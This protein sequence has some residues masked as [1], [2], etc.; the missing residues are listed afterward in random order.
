MVHKSALTGSETK[1]KVEYSQDSYRTIWGPLT[2]Q[3]NT[4]QLISW[5]PPIL[6]TT[7]NVNK[8]NEISA[9][10][11][12]KLTGAL[13]VGKKLFAQLL[14]QVGLTWSGSP[15]DINVLPKVGWGT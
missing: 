10:I 5:Y 7:L 12:S 4:I 11:D 14:N 6:T 8:P 1:I 3:S 13:A 2:L 9:Q 15:T